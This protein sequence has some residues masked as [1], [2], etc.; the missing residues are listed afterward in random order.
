M[1][2]ESG[3][4]N[5]TIKPW[6]CEEAVS[7]NR[8]KFA[9]DTWLDSRCLMNRTSQINIINKARDQFYFLVGAG[10]NLINV[11]FD[12]LPSIILRKNNYL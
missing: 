7:R 4:V 6:W 10:L 8:S 2:K 1:E 3:I 9:N 5:M 12:T 11:N